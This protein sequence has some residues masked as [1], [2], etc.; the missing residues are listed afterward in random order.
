MALFIWK[1]ATACDHNPLFRGASANFAALACYSLICEGPQ[2]EKRCHVSQTTSLVCF[3]GHKASVSSEHDHLS[4]VPRMEFLALPNSNELASLEKAV[5]FCSH[6]ISTE[7][8]RLIS[9]LVNSGPVHLILSLLCTVASPSNCR[10]LKTA[11]TPRSTWRS[12]RS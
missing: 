4:D 1:V 10:S 8:W 6:V 3:P 2:V 12:W 5:A 7:L 11:E 9:Y